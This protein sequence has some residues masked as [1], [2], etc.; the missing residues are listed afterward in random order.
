MDRLIINYGTHTHTHTHAQAHKQNENSTGHAR[1]AALI[2]EE[3]PTRA[4]H[5]LAPVVAVHNEGVE[6]ARAVV[7]RRGDAEASPDNPAKAA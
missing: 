5:G 6:D 1:L 7:P 4:H 3:A 2:A